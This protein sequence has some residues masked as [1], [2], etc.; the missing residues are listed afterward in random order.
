MLANL[1][2]LEGHQ[3]SCNAVLQRIVHRVIGKL[4]VE[5]NVR[6]QSRSDPCQLL[7]ADHWSSPITDV[8]CKKVC[9]KAAFLLASCLSFYKS[10]TVISVDDPLYSSWPT[11]E[12]DYWDGLAWFITLDDCTPGSLGGIGTK[13][14]AVDT[15]SC[16]AFFFFLFIGF[17]TTDFAE[18]LKKGTHKKVHKQSKT[19]SISSSSRQPWTECFGF[20]SQHNSRLFLLTLICRFSLLSPVLHVTCEKGNAVCY[21]TEPEAGLFSNTWNTAKPGPPA[22]FNNKNKS[23]SQYT[24]KVVLAP[25][26]LVIY[27]EDDL[28]YLDGW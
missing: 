14:T 8:V 26:T 23:F 16:A 17:S 28:S 6:N 11:R 9:K 20:P 21:E 3:R 22:F 25:S 7:Y 27:Q 1:I 24:F 10:M 2:D 12:R 4:V 5:M 18:V 15:R 19:N 13:C